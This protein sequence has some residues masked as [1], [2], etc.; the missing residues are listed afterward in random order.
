MLS[1]S[2]RLLISLSDCSCVSSLSFPSPAGGVPARTRLA[3]SSSK[4]HYY[5][6]PPHP[7]IFSFHSFD[8]AATGHICKIKSLH[9]HLVFG[10]LSSRLT[11]RSFSR[12][13]S[14]GFVSGSLGVDEMKSR[15]MKKSSSTQSGAV[16]F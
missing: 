6:H 10:P 12:R 5:L 16:T 4:S 13:S 2:S 15:F 3:H 1:T 8:L 14:E 7:I 11:L 9:F